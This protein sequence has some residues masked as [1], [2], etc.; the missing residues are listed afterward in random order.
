[1]PSFLTESFGFGGGGGTLESV[2]IAYGSP[3]GDPPDAPK[4]RNRTSGVQN[5]PLPGKVNINVDRFYRNVNIFADIRGFYD[6]FT[7]KPGEFTRLRGSRDGLMEKTIET[8]P[9]RLI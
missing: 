1:M 7:E 8:E 5:T 2:G 9:K 4:F 6:V 3:V